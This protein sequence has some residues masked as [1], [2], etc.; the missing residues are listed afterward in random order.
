[1]HPGGL[2]AQAPDIFSKSF[3][4]P[5]LGRQLL[6]ILG[7]PHPLTEVVEAISREVF[8]AEALAPYPRYLNPQIF[9]DW[10][11]SE[12]AEFPLS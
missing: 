9:L 12:G 1:M 11:T 5:S 2:L 7:A 6:P 8:R 3:A 10:H 4:F